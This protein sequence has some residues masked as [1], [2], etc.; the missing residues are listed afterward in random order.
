MIYTT[1]VDDDVIQYSWYDLGKSHINFSV[2]DF[3]LSYGSCN[4]SLPSTS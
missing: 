2:N 4:I 1:F 3:A